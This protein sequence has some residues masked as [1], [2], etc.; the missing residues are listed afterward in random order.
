MT[1]FLSFD[2]IQGRVEIPGYLGVAGP[3]DERRLRSVSFWIRTTQSGSFGTICYWG[4]RLNENLNNGEE[5]RIRLKGNKLELFGRGSGVQTSTAVN[6]GNWHH[7][8]F[9]YDPASP[10]P[11]VR[12]FADA[13]VYVDT[14]QVKGKVFEDGVTFVNT[15]G[16]QD[17]V[18]GAR[19]NLSGG[20]TD[21]FQG[22]LDEFAV[23]RDVIN[24]ATITGSYNGGIRGANLLSIGQ[25]GSLQVW[26][27]MGDAVGD[28]VPSG[29]L[30]SGTLV[31]QSNFGR[32]GVTFSGVSIGL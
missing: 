6:D 2:G 24:T 3:F 9:S 4:A 27:R 13:T 32:H 22:D 1:N 16:E 26:Y 31:D 5:N 10:H 12:N 8:V 11:F 23:Y 14:V 21:F 19:P 25:A 18:I 28:T 29:V 20:F 15:P 30:F 7:V 17:V